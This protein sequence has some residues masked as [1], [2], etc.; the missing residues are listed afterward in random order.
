MEQAGRENG[1]PRLALF[2][3]HAPCQAQNRS[4]C[5][6]QASSILS[7]LFPL[8][9]ALAYRFL[10]LLVK[11]WAVPPR[12]ASVPPLWP[13]RCSSSALQFFRSELVRLAL[14]VERLGRSPAAS[15]HAWQ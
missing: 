3:P 13:A 7:L 15:R 2:F 8:A 1:V 9:F 12:Q 6:W 10:G 11:R 4:G 5:I 14:C